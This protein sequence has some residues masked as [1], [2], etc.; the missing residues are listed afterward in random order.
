MQRERSWL[1]IGC[2]RPLPAGTTVG[3]VSSELAFC[4]SRYQSMLVMQ[5]ELAARDPNVDPATVPFGALQPLEKARHRRTP[6]ARRQSAAAMKH[7]EHLLRTTPADRYPGSGDPRLPRYWEMGFDSP[8]LHLAVEPVAARAGVESSAVL[9]TAFA[10]AMSTATGIG[11][12]LVQLVAGNRSG[13]AWPTRSARSTRPACACWTWPA[14]AST[15][16][17]TGPGGRR[18]PDTS[19]PTTTRPTWR[20]WSSGWPPS[21]PSRHGCGAASTTAA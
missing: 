16:R 20:R 19:T 1:P 18:S 14:P 10:M 5:R 13:R 17:C 11:P 6:Q 4:M 12:L 15:R 8:A 9:L 7:W 2:A 21:G 3:N